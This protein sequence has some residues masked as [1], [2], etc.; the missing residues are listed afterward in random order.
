MTAARIGTARALAAG[1]AYFALVFAAGF[2][3]GTLRVALVAPTL[4]PVAA[5]A[6]ELPLMLGL[7]WFVCRWLVGRFALPPRAAPRLVMGGV[8]FTLLML[9]EYAVS[10][11]L[12]GRALGEH[13]ATYRALA[14]QLGLAAQIAFALFPLVVGRGAARGTARRR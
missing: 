12:L 13:L 9:A 10:A 5:T 7:A 8:A 6:V 14:A 1:A 3:L 11:L 2:A 4:G